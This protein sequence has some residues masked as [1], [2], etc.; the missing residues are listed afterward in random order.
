MKNNKLIYKEIGHVCFLFAYILIRGCVI[1]TWFSYCTILSSGQG[2]YKH[3]L[4]SRSL[5]VL[6]DFRLKNIQPCYVSVAD[7]AWFIKEFLFYDS[8]DM[9]FKTLYRCLSSH[10]RFET[11]I[12][13]LLPQLFSTNFNNSQFAQWGNIRVNTW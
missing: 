12:Y 6:D 9:L 10:R 4:H 5:S 1:L 2:I 7:V 3:S 8:F 11:I 13:S